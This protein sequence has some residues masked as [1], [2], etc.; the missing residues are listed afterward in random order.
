MGEVIEEDCLDMHRVM[1]TQNPPL[2]YWNDE[3]MKIMHTVQNWRTQG[4]LAY[5]TIDAGPNV[6]II[7]EA[8]NVDKVVKFVGREYQVIINKPSCGARVI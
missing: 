3:T 7:C 1:Q 2:Y 8:D 5:Y 4:I 6:H